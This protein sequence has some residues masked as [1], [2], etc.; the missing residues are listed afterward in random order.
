MH[1]RPARENHLEKNRMTA[2]GVDRQY[3]IAG[4]GRLGIEEG[5]GSYGAGFSMYSA[6]WPLLD[7]YPGHAFQSG[8]FGT[9]MYP[10]SEDPKIKDVWFY[11][12]IEGG[13]GWWRGTRFPTLTPKFTVGA[14]ALGFCAWSNGPGA[15]KGDDWDNPKGHYG[16]A[17]L[18]PNLLWPPDALNIKQ[19]ACG[20]LVGYGYLPLPLTEA[21]ETTDGHP[22]PTGDQCWALFLNTSNFRGPATFVLPHFFAKCS[23][24]HPG[25]AGL[26]L[27]SRPA[28]QNR[29][30]SM[31][32][33]YLP[34]AQ[35]TDGDGNLYA[36]LAPVY[37]PC[38]GP[39]GARGGS[40]PGDGL[41]EECALGSRQSMV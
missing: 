9:W 30:H 28:R 41:Q 4:Y 29:T 16:S 19:G 21:K 18:S 2:T 1:R 5:D 34:W 38:G 23:I 7:T 39:G 15:G 6:A 11:N 13:L 14:V 32:T 33:Q 20:E 22:V 40:P 12:T 25:T 36:R 17:Q 27:D 37:L 31:E 3:H 26:F 24:E 10:D 35:A 8:L